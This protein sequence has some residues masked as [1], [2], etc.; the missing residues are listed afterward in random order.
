M[1]KIIITTLISFFFSVIAH[2]SEDEKKCR[3]LDGFKKIGKGSAE[4]LK[5]LAKRGKKTDLFKFNTESRLT[6]II[7]GKKKLE[8]P[9]PVKG[10]KNIKKAVTPDNPLKK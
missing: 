6:D 10:I 9:N 5:C 8:L 1:K 2:A 3:E 7:T 4:F